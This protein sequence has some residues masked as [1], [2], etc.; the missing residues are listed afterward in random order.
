M[1][2]ATAPRKKMPMDLPVKKTSPWVLG[3]HGQA[4]KDGGR[5]DDGGSGGL[6]Q[7]VD[8]AGLLH[9][10]AEEKGP[11][12]RNGGWGQK[13]AQEHADHGKEEQF[14]FGHV[15]ALA[16]VYAPLVLGGQKAHDGGLNKGNQGHVGVGGDGD[17]SDEVG[18]RAWR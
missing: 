10:V 3:A 7:S 4:E 18:G 15:P 9:D 1:E 13:A 11:E 12:Q 14:L 8:H 17:G 16:H 5:V 2:K 6:G